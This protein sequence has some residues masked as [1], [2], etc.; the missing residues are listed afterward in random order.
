M[1]SVLIC[2]RRKE[3]TVLLQRFLL[4]YGYQKGM[5]ASSPQQAKKLLELH[6]CSL[7]IIELPFS[8]N[9][10]ETSFL[11][12]IQE[13]SCAFVIVII[14]K[15]QYL[16]IKE[17][18]ESFGIFTIS[19][20]LQ[21]DVFEQFLAFAKTA[22][23]RMNQFNQRQEQL[24]E[25]IKEIKA[26]DKAKCLLIENEYLSEEAAHKQIEKTAMNER[27]SRGVIAQRIIYEYENRKE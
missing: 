8:Q 6:R 22:F 21:P 15:Q 7:I 19:K 9:A 26:V 24:V 5:T 27:V 12:S 23:Y 17:R 13:S 10:H 4:S 25:K 1:F 18:L 16:S 14:Q 11:L 2:S 3:N 20:P